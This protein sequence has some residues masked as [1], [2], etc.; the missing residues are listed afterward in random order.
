MN[1]IQGALLPGALEPTAATRAPASDGP[2]TPVLWRLLQSLWDLQDM[3]PD[4][5]AVKAARLRELCAW[6]CELH[7]IAVEIRGALPEGPAIVVS[8]HLGYIDPVV[9]CSLMH[10]SPIAKHEISDWAF[11]G[12]PLANL[13]VSF[14]RRGSAHSGA[15]VLRRCLSN[16]RAGL[17]VLNF[18]EGT[19][20]R[21]V[22][23]LP[24]HLGAFWLSRRTGVPIVPIGM[25]FES[26]DLCWVDDDGF[27]PHYAK[28]CVRARRR[29]VR[30]SVASALDP[31]RYR[32]E[33]DLCWAARDAILGVRRPYGAGSP[34]RPAAAADEPAPFS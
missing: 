26:S 28:L 1:R 30:V 11:V 15:R 8:N 4:E 6:A 33:I 27:L 2:S 13:N 12:A 10:V 5:L 22:G 23:L 7:H 17:S 14:V 24:F 25:D 29:N 19:T 34:N 3:G 31:A 32:S 20:S 9:L 16:L 18:P 21:G